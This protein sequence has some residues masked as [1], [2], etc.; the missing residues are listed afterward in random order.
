[1][2]AGKN[3]CVGSSP[4]DTLVRVSKGSFHERQSAMP[5]TA[6]VSGNVALEK[7]IKNTGSPQTAR[8]MDDSHWRNRRMTNVVRSY[9]KL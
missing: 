5:C 6:G 3:K 8:M 4:S 7:D 2:R 1:M 9:H